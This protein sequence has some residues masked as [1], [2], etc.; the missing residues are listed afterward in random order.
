MR[1]RA[2]A[3]SEDQSIS[4]LNL[5]ANGIG[6]AGAEALGVALKASFSITS[7]DCSRNG[8]LGDEGA[9]HLVPTLRSDGTSISCIRALN[10]L[11][12]GIG[13]VGKKT[14]ARKSTVG[15]LLLLLLVEHSILHSART[16]RA[17]SVID[18]SAV[19]SISN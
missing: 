15:G 12:C 10:L 9:K 18:S 6:I 4:T 14:K 19:I 13:D 3:W 5:S 1:K 7:V 11:R 16:V 17:E 8:A 2:H